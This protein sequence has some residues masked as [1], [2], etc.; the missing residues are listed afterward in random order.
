MINCWSRIEKLKAL[1]TEHECFIFFSNFQKVRETLSRC[2]LVLDYNATLWVAAWASMAGWEIV[3]PVELGEPHFGHLEL[4]KHNYW[5][6]PAF[7]TSSFRWNL[8]LWF[9]GFI[10]TFQTFLKQVYLGSFEA[11]EPKLCPKL[12]DT[13]VW[14]TLYWDLCIRKWLFKVK[15]YFCCCMIPLCRLSPFFQTAVYTPFY[16]FPSFDAFHPFASLHKTVYFF[17]RSYRLL[18]CAVEMLLYW[19]VGFQKCWPPS[20]W[21]D[22]IGQRDSEDLMWYF[23]LSVTQIKMA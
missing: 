14:G 16:P 3:V 20:L 13:K 6:S 19:L 7:Q 18:S 10:R 17:G 11:L 21:S 4:I 5:R 1:L 8:Q 15:F 22:K 12:S 2:W 9:T 23:S